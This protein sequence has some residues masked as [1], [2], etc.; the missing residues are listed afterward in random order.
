MSASRC[1][2]ICP[3]VQAKKE[4]LTLLW[5]SGASESAT[6]CFVISLNICYWLFKC[7]VLHMVCVCVVCV[8]ACVCWERERERERESHH[9]VLCVCVCVRGG[10]HGHI[11]TAACVQTHRGATTDSGPPGQHIHSGPPAFRSGGDGGG[12]VWLGIPR[13]IPLG[14]N[15]ELRSRALFFSPFSKS[16]YTV[17]AIKIVQFCMWWQS[18]NI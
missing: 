18:D 13:D 4:I 5:Q 7:G 3:N 16:D 6:V 17:S 1:G 10:R 8:R 14:R 12:V 2:N 9:S 11:T 15:L